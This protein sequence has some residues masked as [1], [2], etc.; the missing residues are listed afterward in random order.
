M[1]QAERTTTGRRRD[2]CRTC[3]PPCRTVLLL[4]MVFSGAGLAQVSPPDQRWRT[5]EEPFRLQMDQQVPL[6]KRVPLDWG[7][8]FR[9][10]VWAIDEDVD[11]PNDRTHNG[12]HALRWQQLRLW[13]SATVD[14]THQFY[15]RGLLDY[16]DW[17]HHTSY[18][19]RDSDWRGFDLERG[20]YDFRLSRWQQARGEQP[21][22]VDLGVTVGRQYVEF[23]T[24]LALS[25]P[26]DA[27]KAT[28]YCRDWQLTGLGAL[29][30]PSTH[31]VDQSVP[32][33]TH[34]S[35][36][37]WG[38][39]LRYH[40]APD[41]EPFAYY[42][43]QDDQ[44]AG[45]IRDGYQFGYD[46]RY[47]GAGSRGRFFRRDLQ[48]TCEVVG[49]F[50]NSYA[51][52]TPDDAVVNDRQ[53]VRA[54]ALDAE[55]RYVAPDAHRSQ[56][57]VEYLLASGDSDRLFSPTN[58]LGGN[59]LHTTDTSF[60]GWGYRDTG[61]VLAPQISNLGVVRL[62]A[63]TFPFN[64]VAACE[65]LEAGLDFYLFHKQ[66]AAGAASDNF[67]IRDHAWLG[68]EMDFSVN[69]RLLSDLAW[70]FRYGIFLPGEAFLT[71]K[72]RQ[73]VFTGV[74]LSF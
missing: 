7:G 61:L 11:R 71:Q 52:Q 35:R 2:Y 36:R 60:V 45:I 46:S 6:E 44:D 41:H 70:F 40:G 15:A 17:N 53:T 24:G 3:L 13:G 72:D 43:S 38:V 48:Y 5:L 25:L 27:V 8:W 4:V 67:S 49:E 30:V 39:E 73:L 29:S 37:Y 66:Q 64:R 55:L 58:T 9:S 16:Y 69:W 68:T 59:R 42:L 31:N 57:A 47:V 51:N 54:W 56:I 32:G 14:Q 22:E 19:G 1:R 26:L 34:E 63:S 62:G 28:G 50:G 18:N 65:Q 20:W 23:G 21:G 74:T 12:Y 33:N 10:S